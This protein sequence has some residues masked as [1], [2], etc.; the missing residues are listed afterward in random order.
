MATLTPEQRARES[1][2]FLAVITDWGFLIPYSAVGL[3]GGSLTIVAESLRAYLMAAIE[4]YSLIVMRRIHRGSFADFEFGTGKL[5][6]AC[7]LAIATGMIVGA[8]WI[9]RG[10]VDLVL[11]GHSNASPLGLTLA[12]VAGAANTLVNFVAW[13]EVRHATRRAPSVIMR[14]QLQARVTKLVASSVVQV[15]LTVAAIA[16]DPLIAAGADS[17]GALFV[18]CYMGVI[19]M[20]MLRVG[21][22]ELLDRSVDEASKNAVLRSLAQHRDEYERLSRI[23]SRRSGHLVFVE[24][25]LGFD[26]ALPLATVDGRVAAIKGTIAR[27]IAGVDVSV[28]VSA[29]PPGL[30]AA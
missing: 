22:P 29:H 2:L 25:A 27:E 30:A 8:L 20:G 28:L 10:A 17:I 5:E 6:Q 14:A 15:T 16:R 4:A 11:Q 9:T 21:L 18:A 7:N 12:A 26:P 3:V 23:R 1:S 19:A 24:I 13:A